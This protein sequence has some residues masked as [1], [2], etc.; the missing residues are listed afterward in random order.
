M[1]ISDWST[2]PANNNAAPPTGAPE[3]MAAASVNNTMREMM[4]DIK[5]GV[6]FTLDTIAIAKALDE[7]RLSDGTTVHVK[8]YNSIADGGEN[9]FQWNSSSTATGDGGSVIELDS[10]P[11]TGRLET[12][13]PNRLSLLQFGCRDGL[14]STAA[15]ASAFA[16]SES[17]VLDM[18]TGIF[19]TDASIE[20]PTATTLK[21]CGTAS[22][23]CVIK[24]TATLAATSPS[25]LGGTYTPTPDFPPVMFCDGI[26]WFEWGAF[27]IDGAGL[28]VIGMFMN[29]A[30]IGTYNGIRTS[31]CNQN[32][33]VGIRL[34]NVAFEQPKFFTCG[35]GASGDGGVLLW[36]TTSISFTNANFERLG[37]SNCR[38][39]CEI[40]QGNNKG[41][42][43]FDTPYFET[44]PGGNEPTLGHFA[45]SG[46][47]GNVD[48]LSATW[49]TPSG[50]SMV[51]LLADATSITRHGVVMTVDAPEG[52]HIKVNDR[53]SLLE[54]ISGSGAQGNVI[55]G[56]F[57]ST[58]I[59][60]NSVAGENQF[61]LPGT[62]KHPYVI[63]TFEVRNPV[64]GT[65]LPIGSANYRF[66][67][68]GNLINY[69]GNDNN[70]F[71]LTGG[72]L[73]WTSNANYSIISGAA[74]AFTAA[75]NSSITSTIS[76][77][78][79][80]FLNGL[81]TSDPGGSGK[82]WDNSGVLSIT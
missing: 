3:G 49:T 4:A 45:V 40:R 36:D 39:S 50:V 44:E 10:A 76:G 81:P 30:F 61:L 67:V 54:I 33:F 68:D 72:N 79:S 56:F 18:S 29:E 41:G 11:S 62:F 12:L 23:T 13:S 77:T 51:D 78:G 64:S 17:R 43:T 31:N 74:L 32:P 19:L 34:Q 6:S 1:A 24:A 28:D 58:L 53:T 71:T 7:T 47:M 46:R 60:E 27:M 14:D 66:K 2:T 80:Y 8:G 21:S 15:L 52:W 37:G 26:Q 42:W 65:T 55:E 69:F 35:Q 25:A 70:S 57:N 38:Y 59:T 63:E 22:D 9:V 5:D 73:I 16:W 20:I 75:S 48:A 82:V